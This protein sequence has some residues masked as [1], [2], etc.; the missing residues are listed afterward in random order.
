MN[1]D[2]SKKDHFILAVNP[3]S[4]SAKIALFKNE[5]LLASQELPRKHTGGIKG[6]AFDVEVESYVNDIILLFEK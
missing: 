3:G 4:T 2:T 5:E 6:D 1:T